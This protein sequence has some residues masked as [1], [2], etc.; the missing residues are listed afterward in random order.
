MRVGGTRQQQQQRFCCCQTR[1]QGNLWFQRNLLS[2]KFV[3]LT[4]AILGGILQLS[5]AIPYHAEQKVSNTVAVHQHNH[6]SNR[7]IRQQREARHDEEKGYCAPYN[8]KICKNFINTQVW[9]SLEDPSGGWKNEQVATALWEELIIDL[10]G[11]CRTAAEVSA[12]KILPHFVVYLKF[13]S[14]SSSRIRYRNCCVPMPFPVAY[15]KTRK[16][17]NCPCVMRTVWPHI[18]NTATMIGS[19]S[20]RKRNVISLS[21]PGDIFVCP[22]VP[23]C[24]NIIALPKNPLAPMLVL[25]KSM[26]NRLHVSNYVLKTVEKILIAYSNFR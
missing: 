10:T 22:T 2:S 6:N 4:F 24:Q 18:Y 8:G 17:L 13:I 23:Y 9:Y 16:Q 20:R 3:F 11:V 14:S 1:F 19:S 26:N 7:P 25:P 5:T 12:K 21:K 15:M